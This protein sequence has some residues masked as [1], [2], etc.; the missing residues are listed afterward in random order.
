MIL[1]KIFTEIPFKIQQYSKGVIDIIT[2]KGTC[3]VVTV[4]SLKLG[5][6]FYKHQS[7]KLKKKE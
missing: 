5:G 1:T 2:V 4:P 7:Y 6:H 3:E